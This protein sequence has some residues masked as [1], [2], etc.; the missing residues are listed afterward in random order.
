MDD[1][2]GVGHQ[3]VHQFGVTDVASDEFDFL[4]HWCQVLG[5]TGVG[6]FVDNS[7]L[8][9]RIII[10]CVVDEVGANKAGAASDKQFSHITIV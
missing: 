1:D 3:L 2:V 6:Q 10:E 9:V 8:I 7:D 5:V 4:E